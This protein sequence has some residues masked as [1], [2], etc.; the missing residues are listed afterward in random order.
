M[1]SVT[2]CVGAP[3][4]LG[5]R[6]GERGGTPWSSGHT[7]PVPST[8][9]AGS[10]RG[11][12]HPGRRGG[13]G[14]A[15]AL[16]LAIAVL[17][18][19][20]GPA[21]AFVGVLTCAPFLAAV[22]ARPL[23]TAGVG[24]TA[25]GAG[26]ALGALQAAAVSQAQLVRLAFIAA[27]AVLAVLAATIRE[28]RDLRMAELTDVAQVAQ[29]VILRPVPAGVGSLGL[30]ARYAS[31]S[32]AASIGG[33]LYDVADTPHGVRLVIG[34][35]RGKG[36]DAVR[37]A[38]AVLAS[39]REA[40]FTAGPDLA[41]VAG[42][43]AASVARQVEQEDFVTAV[44]VQ[45]DGCGRGR[46]VNCGHPPPLVVSPTGG[47]DLLHPG[48][49]M[50]PLGLATTVE[51]RPFT[52]LP[53][54]RLLLYT[55]GLT[56]A[57][58]V[59]RAFFDLERAAQ[60]LAGGS[61]EDAL[62]RLVGSVHSHTG[63]GLHDDLA[64]VLVENTHATVH[65]LK[66]GGRRADEVG[67]PA[68]ASPAADRTSTPD[69]P[70]AVDGREGGEPGR[71]QGVGITAEQ[72][73]TF[74]PEPAST[75]AARRFLRLALRALGRE[76]W[77]EDGELALSEVLTNAVLHANTPVT[78]TVLVRDEGVLVE[79][80]DG[81]SSPPAAPGYG[82]TATTG[83]GMGLVAAVTS[84]CGVR[85][86]D[87]GK[88]VWFRLEDRVE[89]PGREASADDVLAA[90]DFADGWDQE[91]SG[92][93]GVR[94]VRLVDMPAT[95]WLAARQHQDGLLRELALY[96]AAHDEV[97]V[98]LSAA[99]E[100]HTAVS[101]AVS[102]H[103]RHAD[104]EGLAVNPLPP[105]HP[106]PLPP[107]PERVDLDLEVA[108]GHGPAFAALQDALDVAERLAAGGRLLARPG[109]PEIVAVRDWV[110]DQVIAQL[111]GAPPNP[112]PGT[113]QERFETAAP[114][115]PGPEP[116]HWDAGE[117]TD[118]SRGVVAAD[119]ANRIIAVS[120]PLARMLGWRVED[121]VGR[122]VVT[123]IPPRLREAHVA[124]FST[125]LS[126][127]QAHVLGVPLRL[128]ALHADGREL[129][130]DYLV[131]AV[132]AGSGRSVYLAWIEPC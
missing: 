101:T 6:G 43:V 4:R 112:W 115:G 1:R 7:E 16:V 94:H 114:P 29:A 88:V 119:D 41:D 52:L 67:E 77:A 22:F 72:E 39:F 58:D 66:P 12:D 24:I 122:R 81:S 69:G 2:R 120:R 102:T 25:L 45:L 111:A 93:P 100:A 89:E 116:A 17:D 57:R 83:R 105:G 8:S 103:L 97:Q 49:T 11:V 84:A 126:T 40:A 131:E 107:V 110:A 28:R 117:V 74:P 20:E 21:T 65:G 62:T 70:A 32:A 132:P 92:V 38:S 121:L 63:G 130:C 87:G 55:D 109:L 95:L 86:V 47:V 75:P 96:C 85:P 71:A 46:V 10:G 118:S 33:D 19:A 59:D 14:A 79:V 90:W 13:V 50:P 42:Q 76:R 36:L 15:L 91:P 54:Q 23:D 106:S 73:A 18:L 56:E 53:A 129:D 104:G 30:A 128:P 64:A 9:A 60:D 27:A 5:R 80:L 108:A 113:A 44:F 48:W 61:L 26:I 124:G 31:A 127:G 3:D 34:D 78:V 37:L 68:P 51:S 125:H 98:D 35:V 123:I 82:T 99:N